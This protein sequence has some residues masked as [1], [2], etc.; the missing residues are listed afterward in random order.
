[1]TQ[2]TIQASTSSTKEVALQVAGRRA[3]PVEAV[4]VAEAAKDSLAVRLVE[5]IGDLTCVILAVV[6]VSY[7]SAC[8]AMVGFKWIS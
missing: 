4:R 2:V 5:R 3:I 7:V 8:Q 1:M 6:G